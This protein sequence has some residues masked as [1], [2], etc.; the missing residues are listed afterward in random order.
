[1]K[2]SLEKYIDVRKIIREKNKTLSKWLPG[3]VL[4][5]IKRIVHE[6]DINEIMSKVGHL[7]GLDFVRAGL[8]E[9]NT[10][11]KTEGLENIPKEGGC[12]LA[13]NHPLG[14]LDG[15]AFMKA[16]G[17]VRKDQKFIVNDILLSIENLKPL[18]LG[19]NKHGSNP[20]EASRIIEEGYASDQA[21][22]VFPA[23]MVSRKLDTG[24]I[25]DLD[26]KKSFISKAKK[27]ERNII[28][29]YIDGRNS[30][31]FY[32]LSRLRTKIGL[33]A[34]LEMFYLANEMFKQRNKT[35]T[36][37]FG[38]PVSYKEFDKSKS[39][40]EWAYEMRTRVYALGNG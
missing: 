2:K 12:I 6:K 4:D 26:W 23:G 34:N 19:V 20:R 24:V 9:L 28:P 39:L 16:V 25:G 10:T 30:N 32:N 5:Y 27:Y 11:I 3:F 40:V 33:K 7:H 31:F 17:E 1:L 38:T 37:K 36:I 21:I 22:L 35:I 14:G 8:D 15:I 18:F 29:V 13:S